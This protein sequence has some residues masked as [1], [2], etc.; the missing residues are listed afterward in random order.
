MV[1]SSTVTTQVSLSLLT[2]VFH[3]SY[4]ERELVKS[5][6]RDVCYGGRV[7]TK[8]EKDCL[9]NLLQL[10]CYESTSSEQQS[11]PNVSST[12]SKTQPLVYIHSKS[13]VSVRPFALV[14]KLMVAFFCYMYTFPCRQR[15]R[16]SLLPCLRTWLSISTLYLT[17]ILLV[18]WASLRKHGYL[19]NR[20]IQN[21]FNNPSCRW[22]TRMLN[23]EGEGIMELS[24]SLLIKNLL[25]IQLL[26]RRFGT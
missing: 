3:D 19:R 18:S 5:L 25:L 16:L 26:Q 13:L 14:A 23:T 24:K 1:D 17:K 7:T 20:A 2:D 11:H 15:E 8:H 4:E 10:Y 22:M 21:G 9:D 6:V 12:Y